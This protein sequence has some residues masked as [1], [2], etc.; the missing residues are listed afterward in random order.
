MT[1]SK[2]NDPLRDEQ[3]GSIRNCIRGLARLTKET[4]MTVNTM[5]PCP[6]G[7]ESIVGISQKNTAK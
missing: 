3:I 5:R 7:F 1:P 4:D 6:I 2:E